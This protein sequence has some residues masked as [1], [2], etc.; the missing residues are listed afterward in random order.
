MRQIMRIP[1]LDRIGER[2]RRLTPIADPA[3]HD[4][5]VLHCDDR[6]EIDVADLDRRRRPSSRSH[7]AAS[8]FESIHASACA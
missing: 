3:L 2:R 5:A 1:N 4:E 6:E 7:F 8:N